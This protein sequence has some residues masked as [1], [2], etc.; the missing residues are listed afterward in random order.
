MWYAQ[1]L[2]PLHTAE[3]RRAVGRAG[4]LC[5]VVTWR[6][7]DS[8]RLAAEVGVR[9][10]V[11]LVVPDPAYS[12]APAP[13]ETVAAMLRDLGMPAGVRYLAVCPR[14]WLGRKTYQQ[15]LGAAVARV[16]AAHDLAVL[17]VPFQERTDGPLCAELRARPDLAERAW[18]VSGVDD[19]AVIAGILGRSRVRGDHAPAQ[20]DTGCGGRHAG[21]RHRLR[22][23]SA[24][25]SPADRTGTLGGDRRRTG[26]DARADG[27]RRG[28][29]RHRPRPVLA[30]APPRSGGCSHCGRRPA[31]RRRWLCSSLP[32]AACRR[33]RDDEQ[34][35]PAAD[36]AGTR[37]PLPERPDAELG[38]GGRRGRRGSAAST[39][40]TVGKAALIILAATVVGRVFGL[41][42][43]MAVAHFFGA[44]A[45][46][47]A[48]F[49]AYK[50][51]YLL[52]LTVG[53]ALTATFIPVFTQ[54]IVS[55][56]RDEAWKLTVSMTNTVALVLTGL[57][58]ALIILAPWVV[59]LFGP[60]FDPSTMDLAVS[61]FRILMPGVVFAG[62]AGLA[63][64]VLNSLKGFSVPAFSASVGAVVTIVFMAVFSG[65]W[66][67]TSLAV[68]TTA[69]AAATF[70]VLVPQLR[71]KGLRY[72]PRI[73]WRLPGMSQVAI[74]V[75]PILIGS[76]VGKVSIF[77]DQVLGSLLGEGSISALNYSEKLFQLPLGLFVAGITIPIFPLLSE[78]VAARRPDRVNATLAFA[79]RLIAFVI[80]PASVGL[81]V[82]R[83]PIVALLFQ[84]G[85]KFTAD[86]TART[87]WA[88]L[89]VQ[90]RAVLVRRP[91][92]AHPRLLRVSRHAN[93]R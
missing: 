13:V 18:V 10:P 84:N 46:T 78:Q 16:A 75:W 1:G 38:A 2:G 83:V 6:D 56:R 39:R 4:S 55:G 59:P 86:D 15:H 89:H 66:G 37:A 80:V 45:T 64:G 52:S 87:A 76:A 42:R 60:G 58:A 23:Q 63:T 47:D 8:A 68:G 91:R 19:P 72:T 51:P 92:H 49:L 11:Q 9:A 70:L 82:L 43:D 93:A 26:V 30:V 88:L 67:I 31:A 36:S 7:V 5:Q 77:V 69:G 33:V 81:I 48:F 17:F 53:G 27:S 61:L 32:G 12:L 24:R 3:A 54:R 21:R 35:R 71:S 65:S 57:T 44:N 40:A 29:V 73:D 28:A 14:P 79:L 62:L 90:H 85:G 74:M 41:V 34:P 20:R 50:I 25:L 22:P